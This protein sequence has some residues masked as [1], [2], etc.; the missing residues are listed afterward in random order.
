MS[1]I[2][3]VGKDLTPFAGFVAELSA[4]KGVDVAEVHSGSD[5]LEMV[6]SERIDAV[7]LAEE[8]ADGPAL[9][10]IEGLIKKQ[11]LINCAM[12]SDMDPED[13]HEET[14][15]LGI[16]MQLPSCP[17]AKDAVEMLRSLQA[18]DALFG[19]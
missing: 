14:E 13:F 19:S 12:M 2:V 11:P 6:D 3:L 15:G 9:S 7:V 4:R 10:F 17:E 16:F 8:L 5:L 18:I 1:S